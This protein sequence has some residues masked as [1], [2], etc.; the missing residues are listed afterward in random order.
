MSTKP[1]CSL[2]TL[3]KAKVQRKIP[4]GGG[5]EDGGGCRGKEIR[6]EQDQKWLN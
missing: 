5:F 2:R 3:L 1:E 6:C 4:A